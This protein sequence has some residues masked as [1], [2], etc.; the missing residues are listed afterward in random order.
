MN[1]K[2]VD[3][4]SFITQTQQAY[5][6]LP[7]SLRPFKRLRPITSRTPEE[8]TALARAVYYSVKEAEESG[9][10]V[11]TKGGYIISWRNRSE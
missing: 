1:K 2:D 11:K 9:C 3:L 7:R 5:G 4:K 10:F 8:A 6:E